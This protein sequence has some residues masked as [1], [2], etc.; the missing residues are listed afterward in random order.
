MSFA[1]SQFYSHS[2]SWKSYQLLKKKAMEQELS[3]SGLI[4]S[5]SIAFFI[6][7]GCATTLRMVANSFEAKQTVELE[8]QNEQV[9]EWPNMARSILGIKTTQAA[10][11]RYQAS[12]TKSTEFI[13]ATPGQEISLTINFKNTGTDTWKASEASFETG[14]Y[15]KTQSLVKTDVW[16]KFYEPVKLSRDVKPGQSI[17][18]TFPARAPSNIQETI[19]E[20]FQLVTAERP[21]PGSLVRFFITISSPKTPVSLP[22]T[23]VIAGVASASVPII[24]DGAKY[25]VAT[26]ADNSADYS[27][28]NTNKN[29][30]SVGDGLSS[31]VLFATSPIL[32]VG[33]FA[34]TTPQRI[35]VDQMF[36]VYDSGQVL[37]SDMP[38]GTIVTVGYNQVTKQYSVV[39][40]ALTR[41]SVNPIRIVP[42]TKTGI[43]TM[44]DYRL[45][46]KSPDNRF[47]NIIEYRYSEANKTSWVINELGIEDYLKGLAETSNSSPIEFQKVMATAA[48]SYALY[49]Y[50]RGVNNG[51][52]NASTKHA[53]KG[54]HIDSEYD[55]VYRG[56]NS[57][58]RL[59]T[60]AQAVET[61][62]GAVVTFENKPVI[63]PY[64]SNSDGRTRDWTE[65]WGGTAM[66]W[67][68]SVVV[69][70]DIGKALF[71]H[72]VGLSARGALVMVNEGQN[73]QNILKY[74]Y[75]GT[76]IKKIY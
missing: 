73:W 76:E 67:L 19:Q 3:W 48:R 13:N 38:A 54:F 8:H 34:G 11:V 49:H 61:T 74:F 12:V 40:P 1:S 65:V 42:K 18:I 26:V 58:L 23:S 9:I 21:I 10:T 35:T 75:S 71:G 43:V 28:C 45:N 55:Q 27:N 20:N 51:L 5:M 62:R 50:M 29:E 57:E 46:Q 36:D 7:A 69:S 37:F 66:A 32:R 39:A 17:S 24:N 60:L 22:A 15:L 68:K 25:C 30:T 33:L 44:L 14:P 31:T 16:K 6:V 53:T 47:R 56:Y 72:G 70:Q 4:I 41:F 2:V 52:T 63:T 59:P 64:F